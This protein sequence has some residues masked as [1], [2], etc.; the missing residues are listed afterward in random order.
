MN[1]LARHRHWTSAA[2]WGPV[3]LVVAALF[4][5][6]S[7]NGAGSM[8]ATLNVTPGAN[9]YGGQQVVFSGDMGS[10]RQRIRLQRRGSPSAAWADV[11]DPRTGRNFSIVTDRDGSYRFEFPAPAMNA[12]Y[13]RVVSRTA[14]SGEHLFKSKHQ[15]ADVSLIESSPADVPL[16][17]GFAVVGEAFRIAVDTADHDNN[18]KPTKPI[19]PGRKVTLQVR[20]GAGLWKDVPGGSAVVGRD[21]TLSYAPEQRR[22]GT[23][24]PEVYR[25]VMD[26]W[27]EN[28]DRVGWFPSV[29]FYLEVVDRPDP[30]TNLEATAPTSSQVKLAW[31]L[32]AG[33]VAKIVIARRTGG[34]A[35]PTAPRQVIDELPG[36][37]TSYGDR[38]VL[39]S[40]FYQ[41]AVY[42]VSRDGVYTRVPTPVV[43]RTPDSKG[44]AG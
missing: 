16:P 17:R 24:A 37:A 42:T 12:V 44:G 20:D 39:P 8:R 43:V 25:V 34:G 5:V 11:I 10:G 35:P 4:F 3:L 19:L 30:V 32:P 9:S 29:P 26:D 14:A 33:P 27:T 31:D 7:S 6:P 2:L 23:T 13:F 40:D 15:D 28:G 21:G 18:G 36:T 22:V 41:Y 38:S 1:T